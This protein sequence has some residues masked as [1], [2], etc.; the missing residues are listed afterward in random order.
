[1][2]KREIIDELARGRTVERLARSLTRRPVEGDIKDL[3][4]I[5][6]L[7]LL[8]YDDEKLARL[9]ADRELEFLIIRILLN[10]Y[11]SKTSRFFRE[12]RQ[13]SRRVVSA[14]W[15]ANIPDGDG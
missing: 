13:F 9:H 10:Q 15:A 2:T 4:Q 5:V 7:Y 3:C 8:E 6:Y 11:R 1:M 12:C 14:S